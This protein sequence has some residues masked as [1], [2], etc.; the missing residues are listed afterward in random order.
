MQ[1]QETWTLCTAKILLRPKSWL[2]FVLTSIPSY[3]PFILVWSVGLEVACS[4][5][6]CVLSF[7]MQE[8]L[9]SLQWHS[10]PP[11]EPLLE[12]TSS[13]IPSMYIMHCLLLQKTPLPTKIPVQRQNPS[14]H[15]PF[16]AVHA[17]LEVHFFRGA[18]KSKQNNNRALT[19]N[20]K[21]TISSDRVSG[22]RGG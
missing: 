18:R 12:A 10:Q 13:P 4:W 19:Y 17:S 14:S 1:H 20:L 16:S 3:K 8:T 7:Q 5:G 9:I 15:V 6:F 21:L 11:Y 2:F 22:G